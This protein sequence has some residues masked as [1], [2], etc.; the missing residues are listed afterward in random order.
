MMTIGM[1]KGISRFRMN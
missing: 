1:K